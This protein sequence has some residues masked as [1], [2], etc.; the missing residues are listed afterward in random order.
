M[1]K[2]ILASIDLAN[3]EQHDAI[4]TRAAQM[5]DL[6][7]ASLAVVTVIPDFGM[8]IVGSFFETGAEENALKKAAAALHE[9]VAKVLGSDTD[10]QIKHVIRHGTAYEEILETAR[11]LNADLIIMGAH[12]PNYSD[13]LL[14]PNAARVVRH[15]TC[16]VLV[17]RAPDGN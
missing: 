14:G 1:S 7:D 2:L 4:L 12:R 6:D 11:T 10:A 17:L 15:S 9:T 8:S 16:S 5:A 13:Y 3:P